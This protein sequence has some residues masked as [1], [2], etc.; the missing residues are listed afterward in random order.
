[1]ILCEAFCQ[2]VE[3][4]VPQYPILGRVLFSIYSNAIIIS[5]QNGHALMQMMLYFVSDFTVFNC[6]TKIV[7]S[8]ESLMQ[9][10]TTHASVLEKGLLNALNS[11]MPCYCYGKR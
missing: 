4:G 11:I 9:K 6:G 1:M 10:K 8:F 5:S 3:N 2:L 7:F